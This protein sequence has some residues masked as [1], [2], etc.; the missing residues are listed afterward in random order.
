M[1][2][3]SHKKRFSEVV[4]LKVRVERTKFGG[5]TK[6]FELLTARRDDSGK[7]SNEKSS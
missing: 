6:Y 1:G 3:E 7:E 2:K 5:L 4:I